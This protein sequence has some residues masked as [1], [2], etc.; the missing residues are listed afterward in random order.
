VS[1]A[2]GGGAVSQFPTG[3]K[4]V[5]IVFDYAYMAGEQMGI[6]LYN[7]S[8]NVLSEKVKT[9]SGDGTESIG[10]SAGGEGFA[11]GRYAVNIYDGNWRVINTAIWDIAETS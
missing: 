2:P 10:F 1:D 11:V 9:L 7:N 3:T 8:G 6:R 5:Y 4:K